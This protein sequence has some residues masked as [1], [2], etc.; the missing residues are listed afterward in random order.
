M[1][2]QRTDENTYI[3]DTLVTCA[4]YQLFIDEMREQG[5]HYQPDHWTSGQFSAGNAQKPIFG[6]R[7][8]DAKDFCLWLSQRGGDWRYRLPTMDEATE[9]RSRSVDWGLAGHWVIPKDEHVHFAWMCGVPKNARNLK[10][11]ITKEN[12]RNHAA[13][14]LDRRIDD[15]SIQALLLDF[16]VERA[17]ERI[18]N[19]PIDI[20]EDV[21]I[22]ETLKKQV[23]VFSQLPKIQFTGASQ[24][25]QRMEGIISDISRPLPQNIYRAQD[26]SLSIV[27][28][29]ALAAAQ[30]SSQANQPSQDAFEKGLD[31]AMCLFLDFSNIL[32]RKEG[33][34]KAFEGIRLVKERIK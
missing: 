11:E 28:D 16:S 19:N 10:A 20:N 27:L 2:W 7:F 29:L 26:R 13:H 9:F 4:E 12:I 1:S 21:E 3:D 14:Y 33:S 17:V 25:I 30:A 23:D 15:L 18:N 6:A 5:K 22:T 24:I 31:F 32:E 34:A 8:Q